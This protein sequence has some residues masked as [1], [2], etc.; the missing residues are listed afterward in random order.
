MTQF[1]LQLQTYKP[2]LRGQEKRL[3]DYLLAHQ[4]A[5]SELSIGQ[6]AAAT[7]VS[8]ATISRFA[9]ALGYDNFQALRLALAQA[10]AAGDPPLFQEFS[11]DDDIATQAR[12]IFAANIDALQATSENLDPAALAAAVKMITGARQLGL[13]GL[14]A[15]N[16]VALDGYHK[17]LRTALPVA[18]AADFH[19][20]LMS[21]THLTKRDAAVV[22]S[23]S[24]EDRDALALTAIA[25]Q[26][27][28]PLIVIT[29]APHSTVAKQAAVVL[30]AVAEESQYRPE[31]L[32]ALIAEMT[33]M[34]TLFML[35]ALRTGSQTAPL[36]QEI[37]AVIDQTRE[38]N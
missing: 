32:H 36:Y 7:G 12:K 38:K 28:V 19:M 15:S 30:V 23:H 37:R 20:Q 17:F 6:L 5:A 2:R 24:G 26:H 9:K 10:P 18:Y 25:S 34:D 21:I 22:I 8:A 27:H 11:P 3:A 33:L 13:Y 16:L 14:G 4:R 1:A 31:A 29:G 35:S